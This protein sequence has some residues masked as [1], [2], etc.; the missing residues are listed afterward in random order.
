MTPAVKYKPRRTVPFH[1]LPFVG[2]SHHKPESDAISAWDVPLTGGYEGGW[3]AGAA[4][5]TSAVVYF[6][7][8]SRAEMNQFLL[9]HICLAWIDRAVVADQEEL[10]SLRGQVGGFMETVSK[11]LVASV[12]EFGMDL[13]RADKSAIEKRINAGIAFDEKAFFANLPHEE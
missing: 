9:G 7:E 3:R 11:W 13:D 4:A 1:R 12:N 8:E 10:V 6:R 2:R 5:G